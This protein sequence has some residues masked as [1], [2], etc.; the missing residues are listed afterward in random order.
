MKYNQKG[1]FAPF[2]LKRKIILVYTQ[3]DMVNMNMAKQEPFNKR[4]FEQ[5]APG[6]TAE[7]VNY[8]PRGK[9]G[10]RCWEIKAEKPDGDYTI[11]VLRDYGYKID[12]ETVEIKP[13]SSREERN[14][15]IYRLYHEKDI[16]QM[17]L[18]NMFNMSQPSVSLIVNKK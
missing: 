1:A 7:Y 8:M 10:M 6:C 15:E 18:A 13:F 12:G 3:E 5:L 11:V 4:K 16:S 14:A 17:F 2:R 9:N